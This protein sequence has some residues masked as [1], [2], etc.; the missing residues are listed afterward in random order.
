MRSKKLDD[1]ILDQ[2]GINVENDEKFG[3]RSDLSCK[4]CGHGD[5]EPNDS[6]VQTIANTR[7]AHTT[8][9]VTE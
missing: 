2:S 4:N 7:A 3:Q 6:Q 5:S 8:E 9:G 1:F